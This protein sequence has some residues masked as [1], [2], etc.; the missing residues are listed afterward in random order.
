M[1]EEPDHGPRLTDEEYER[2]IIELHRDLP[3]MPAEGQDRQV[4]LM[5]MNLAIG[6]GCYGFSLIWEAASI[7]QD[8]IDNNLHFSHKHNSAYH[9]LQKSGMK[10]ISKFR[11]AGGIPG[12]LTRLPKEHAVYT[13][14]EVA[15]AFGVSVNP[16][17]I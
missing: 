11:K 4:C 7:K 8:G 16:V 3:P 12:V 9:A 15:H 17:Y 10:A 6:G 2:R 14:A 1:P 5:V 13:V